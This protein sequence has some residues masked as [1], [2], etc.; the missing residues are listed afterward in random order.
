MLNPLAFAGLFFILIIIPYASK[1]YFWLARGIGDISMWVS[2]R[3]RWQTYN[4][5]LVALTIFGSSRLVVVWAVYIAARIVL[6]HRSV[7]SVSTSWYHYLLR[8]DSDWYATIVNEGYK[9][10]GNDLVQQSV[11]FYPLYPLIAK[12]LTILLGI[13]GLL[14]LLLLPM[15]P[16]H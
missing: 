12:A 7:P 6:P 15:S 5:Y 16:P 10:N 2:V 11:V 1:C 9:Y 4:P 8:W 13:D 14:A 3:E